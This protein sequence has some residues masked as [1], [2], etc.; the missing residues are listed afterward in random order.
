MAQVAHRLCGFFDDGVK[1]SVDESSAKGAGQAISH[2]TDQSGS[3]QSVL[4][5][6]LTSLSAAAN[7]NVEIFEGDA[8]GNNTVG[9]VLGIY[10][11]EHDEV[12]VI[13]NTNCGSDS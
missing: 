13:A 8:S 12:L 9:T 2:L 7:P 5:E 1:L 3:E 11:L 4:D 6:M 10:D